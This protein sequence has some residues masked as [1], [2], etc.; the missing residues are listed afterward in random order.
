MIKYGQRMIYHGGVHLAL[1]LDQQGQNIPA[2]SAIILAGGFSRRMGTDKALLKLGSRTSVEWVVSRF[3]GIVDDV[4]IVHR[5]GQHMPC[6]ASAYRVC[7]LHSGD[8]PLAG[9]E[10]GLLSAHHSWSFCAPVDAPLLSPTLV[11]FLLSLVPRDQDDDARYQAVIP[12]SND[13]THHLLGVY[14][15]SV[16]PVIST[17]LEHNQ[18]RVAELLSHIRVRYVQPCEWEPYDPGQGS[19]R[20]MNTLAEYEYLH[21]TCFANV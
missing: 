7:D 14:H 15:R 21:A 13:Q 16:L 18:H 17:M 11:T 5:E 1:G 9:L 4:W 2:F 20:V 3:K 12:V 19:F 6:V 10:Q 8:G